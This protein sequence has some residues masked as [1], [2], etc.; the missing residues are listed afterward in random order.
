MYFCILLTPFQIIQAARKMPNI[1]VDGGPYHLAKTNWIQDEKQKKRLGPF[2]M[3][4][5]IANNHLVWTGSRDAFVGYGAHQLDNFSYDLDSFNVVK[6]ETSLP[7]L[8]FWETINDYLRTLPDIQAVVEHLSTL[9][10][11]GLAQVY[12][13]RLINRFQMKSAE[14]YIYHG[15][16]NGLSLLSDPTD[17]KLVELLRMSHYLKAPKPQD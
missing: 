10:D 5:D 6:Y 16:E 1:P 13:G 7:H 4:W 15:R 11:E 9:S 3:T 8:K 12:V 14:G 2:L 17:I